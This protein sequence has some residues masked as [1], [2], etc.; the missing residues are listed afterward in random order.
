MA[1]KEKISQVARLYK[2][3]S[4]VQYEIGQDLIASH[5]RPFPGQTVLDLG[6]GTG[7]LARNIG[8]A[9]AKQG[10]VLGVDPNTERIAVA[11]E[12]ER[13]CSESHQRNVKF[14]TG[15]VHD[16]VQHGPFDAVFSNFAL[17]WVPEDDTDASV[18]SIVKCLK[19][20]G[21]LCATLTRGTGGYAN[22]LSL[23][24]NGRSEESATGMHLRPLNY[25][26]SK[27]KQ[28]GLCIE[29]AEQEEDTT[30]KFPSIR[31]Y[32][33]FVKAYT[34]AAID[35]ESVNADDLADFIS[36]Q[37]LG[38]LDSPFVCVATIL[39]IIASKPSLEH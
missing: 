28:A 8:S 31:S 27:L 25:W 33:E 32:F 14:M 36:N 20:G 30:G 13:H 29:H 6:C 21:R 38:S 3:H 26:T 15:L 9:V 34:E 4:S 1:T 16:A 12:E 10:R 17:H 22:Q 18:S 24:V 37:G 39:T 23:F 35:Y 11:R 7:S 19:P 2:D 5:M